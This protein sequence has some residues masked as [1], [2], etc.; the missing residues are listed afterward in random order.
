M[1]EL[2]P[3]AQRPAESLDP[4]LATDREI[5]PTAETLPRDGDDGECAPDPAGDDPAAAVVD[6][7]P[8]RRPGVFRRWVVRPV[9]WGLVALVVLFFVLQPLMDTRW[10]RDNLRQLTAQQIGK[11]FDRRVEIDDLRIQ[12][13]PLSVEVWGFTISG[14]AEAPDAT[15]LHVPFAAVESGDLLGLYRRQVHLRQIRA[16]RPE[17]QLIYFPD[18]VHNIVS[19][20]PKDRKPRKRRWD[21]F[22]DRLEVDRTE[23]FID[24]EKV[25]LSIAADAVQLRME[26]LGELHLA[27]RA[28]AQQVVVRLPN[29]RPITVA[30]AARGQWMRRRLEIESARISGPDLSILAHGN[31]TWTRDD[32]ESR[33]CQITAQ[34]KAEGSALADLGYFADLEG[35]FDFD[36]ALDWRPGSSGWR[37]QVRADDV[38][39]W[40]RR[41]E[42]LNGRLVADRYGARF[43]IEGARYAGGSLTGDVVYDHEADG[44]PTAFDLDFEDV[45]VDTLLADQKIPAHGCASRL[46]GR[47]TYTFRL[48][49]SRRGEGRAEVRL[50]PDPALPG[51]ALAGAFPLRIEGGVV[52]SDAASLSSRQ[53]GLLARGFYD[54]E[55][56]RGR[57]DYEVA[58]A[59]L[60]QLVPML[61]VGQQQP[62]PLWLPQAGRGRL[63]GTLYL[64]PGE[65]STDLRLRFEQVVTPS[66][67]A[68]RASGHFHLDSRAVSDLVL[69]LGDGDEALLLSGRIPLLEDD[70]QGLTLA[71]DGYGWPMEA[72]HPW[73]D[74]DLPVDGR[75]SG[76]LVV[77]SRLGVTRGELDATVEE[78][79]LR[80]P[81][82]E[83]S[84]TVAVD[85]LITDLSWD[86]EGLTFNRLDLE[87]ASGRLTGEGHYRWDDETM[88][89][90]FR[91][92]ALELAAEPL[93]SYL[94]RDDIAGRIAIDA[95]LRGRWHEPRVDLTVDADALALSER[96]LSGRPSHLEMHWADRRLRLEGRLLELV[97]VAGGGRLG[98]SSTDLEFDLAGEDVAGLLELT[99]EE[100]PEIDGRFS[101]RLTI[102]DAGVAGEDPAHGA[103]YRLT[104]EDLDLTLRQ[105][106][107]VP[108]GPV[109]VR[110]G[111][112][113]IHLERF[114]FSEPTTGSE[115]FIRGTVGYGG[116]TPVDL[117]MQATLDAGWL[118]YLDLG[119]ELE[120]EI[121]ALGRV[122]G[123]FGSFTFDGQTALRRGSLLLGETF[124][125]RVEEI[126]GTVQVFPTGVLIERLDGT[127]AQG[128]VTLT[129]RA[130]FENPGEP[131]RYRLQATARDL[132][133][134]YPEGWLLRGDLD[135]NLRSVGGG[136]HVVDGR[137]DLEGIEFSD[138][139]R[140]DFEQ[141]MR[142]FLRRQRLEVAP[143]DSLL[144]TI[145]LDV[146]IVGPIAVRN[147]LA[148][149]EGRAD[150]L[151]RGDLAE[152]VLYG[153]VT[154]AAGGK[155]LYNNAEYELERGR[156]VFR[157][158]WQLDPEVDLVATTRV[159]DFDVTLVLGGTFDRLETRFSSEPPLPDLEVFRLL[160]TGEDLVETEG[161]EPRLTERSTE[162]PS[163][164]AA[165]FLYGQAASVIGSRVNRLFGFD[166]FRIDPLTGSGDNLSKAQVTVGK[167][168]SKDVFVTYS[169]DPTSTENQRLQVEWQVSPGLVLVLTQNGDDTYS[170]DARWE[171][172]F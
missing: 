140:L 92:P 43:R 158:P 127:L 97:S 21:V 148:E 94:P 70:P 34:G 36:G 75:V 4:D 93:R 119:F 139:I 12:L 101:A 168:L 152:P 146:D 163:T 132:H 110:L 171:T 108:I 14:P 72:V 84:T 134:R 143:A 137:A 129:G 120:G 39:L 82:E 113:R 69:E 45:L 112:E 38:R 44:R 162:D 107:V 126:T 111:Q 114:D 7:P 106:R 141:L 78:A 77:D 67:R 26:G 124:P 3:G 151:L 116:D 22:I 59:D 58:S 24:Q 10:V 87:A 60:A 73:L 9:V 42:D 121:D 76:R 68:R 80:L 65:T 32:P 144:S 109:R 100:P 28:V 37:G 53:Q 125:Y 17:I 128:P 169:V 40:Q 115:F 166:K 46:D 62:P 63:E 153:E 150:L 2:E 79:R 90:R 156:V 138:D 170:A 20:R 167:R 47:L 160:A 41:L 16:E 85:R 56:N 11:Y 118:E 66:L 135:L 8:C 164:S 86:G 29:A 95:T 74:F 131:L 64:E 6:G 130:D 33:R 91:S 88:D 147:N 61:P 165:V 50:V 102:Q 71:F 142:G 105:H 48:G 155:L 1:A 15:F 149:L 49:D 89:L 54:L 117:M 172:V 99:L 52:R 122:G 35:T 25:R 18:G 23:L 13:V 83:G 51:L 57:F 96:R 123:P 159:R 103:L 154:L 81:T 55:A 161:F 157:N 5:G 136:G 19:F 98:G 27:G 133:L 145:A 30:V 31:C 104:S